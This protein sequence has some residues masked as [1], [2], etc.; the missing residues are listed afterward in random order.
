MRASKKRK[1]I[2]ENLS[3]SIL[4]RPPIGYCYLELEINTK[5]GYCKR[6]RK[7]EVCFFFYT[8]LFCHDYLD[9]RFKGAIHLNVL[10]KYIRM[11]LETLQHDRVLGDHPL[12]ESPKIHV[13]LSHLLSELEKIKTPEKFRI[14]RIYY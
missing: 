7:P 5:E 12:Q 4:E 9:E 6:S 1:E 11:D 8:D 14:Y 13:E 2:M 10:K 3:E